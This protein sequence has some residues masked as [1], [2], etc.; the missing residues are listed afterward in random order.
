MAQ[1][2]AKGPWRKITNTEFERMMA[3]AAEKAVAK[4]GENRVRRYRAEE[5]EVAEACVETMVCQQCVSELDAPVGG[6]KC[7]CH[8]F[9]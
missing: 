1:S 8:E 3:G 4:Y 6:C 5:H 9:C 2:L 7:L